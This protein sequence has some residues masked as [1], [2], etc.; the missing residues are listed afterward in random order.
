[1]KLFLAV[2]L[3]G[4]VIGFSS[5]ILMNFNRVK[6]NNHY[7]LQSMKAKYAKQAKVEVVYSQTFG[8][9]FLT[10]FAKLLKTPTS[11]HQKIKMI[12]QQQMQH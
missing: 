11:F 8:V 4:S 10:A 5:G 3:C 7:K 2:L 6:V 1:M 12:K 9:K